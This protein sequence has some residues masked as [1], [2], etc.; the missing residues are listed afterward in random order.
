M[1]TVTN[2]VHRIERLLDLLP[3]PLVLRALSEPA[4]APARRRP[5]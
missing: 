5:S 2:V 4:D 3:E 1:K